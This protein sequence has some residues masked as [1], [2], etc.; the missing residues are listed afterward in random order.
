MSVEYAR[1]GLIGLLTPQANTTVEPELS[2][3]LPPGFAHV[4]A[5][6]V[7]DKA[8][9]EE[10]LLDYLEVA[11]QVAGQFANAPISSLALGCAGAS[12]LASPATVAASALTGQITDPRPFLEGVR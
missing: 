5:R 1:K 8:T 11:E 9:I 6:L 4:N 12:H 7:S 2:V 10:R 3:L